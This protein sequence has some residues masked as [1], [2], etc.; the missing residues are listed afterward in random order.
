MIVGTVV[1]SDVGF[2]AGC[3]AEQSVGC[4]STVIPTSRGVN[5]VVAGVQVSLPTKQ[6]DV[7]KL[8]SQSKAK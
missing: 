3:S 2:L 7:L 5:L 4:D 1:G 6:P 8:P